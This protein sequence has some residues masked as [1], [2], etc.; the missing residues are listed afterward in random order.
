V[1]AAVVE[2]TPRED[3]IAGLHPEPWDYRDRYIV[4]TNPGRYHTVDRVATDW[5]TKQPRWLRLLSTNTTSK[6]GVERAVDQGGFQ[7]SSSVGSWKVIRRD[8]NE[9]VFSDSTGFM[10]YW[11]S[12]LLPAD[13]PNTVEGS[14]AVRYLWPRA[15]RFYFALAVWP[16]HAT[17]R[18]SS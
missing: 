18:A 7:V 1:S 12:F 2:A 13:E 5:F 4:A 9:I 15:G 6:A 3:S 8:D 10:E 11:Y 14:T 17:L 16:N